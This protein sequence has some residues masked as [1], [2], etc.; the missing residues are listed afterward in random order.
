[1]EDS[2]LANNKATDSHKS[3]ETPLFQEF[4]LNMGMTSAIS[5]DFIIE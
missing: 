3:R 4:G 1:V 5:I 2:L